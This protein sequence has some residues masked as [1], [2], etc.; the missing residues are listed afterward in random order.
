[1]KNK[2]SNNSHTKIRSILLA[3]VR[4]FGLS[5]KIDNKKVRR[6]MYHYFNH[7]DWNY[8]TTITKIETT[9]NKNGLTILIE[10]HRPGVLI[11]KAGLFID[12]LKDW[13]KKDLKRDDIKISLIESK[14]WLT[15]Y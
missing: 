9:E 4:Y 2:T 7:H 13:L 12:G 1:M 3:M 15:L 11:G 6:S 8:C 10:T 5:Y 14:L